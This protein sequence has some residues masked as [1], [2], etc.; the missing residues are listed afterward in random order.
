MASQYKIPGGKEKDVP[1][2]ECTD[3]TLD[4]WANKVAEN[5]A[6][7]AARFPDRDKPF[8][9]AMR[10]EQARRRGEE[11]PDDA[12]SGHAPAEP[13]KAIQRVAPPAEIVTGGFR[14]P[15]RATEALQRAAAHAHLV[16]PATDCGDIREG[17]S[18]VISA[19][20]V[21]AEHETYS[22]AGKLGLSKV[23]LDKIA[24]AAGIS[25]DPRECGRQDDG[26]D[27][28]YCHY[29]AVG[30]VRDFDGTVRLLSGEVEMDAREGSPLIDEIRTK[31]AKRRAEAE[32]ENK[33]YTGDGGDS[34]ILELRKFLLRHAESKAKN[35]AIRELGIRTAYE[36]KE[37]KKPFVVAK[38]ML[39]GH[40]SNPETQRIF[41]EQTAREF[42]SAVPQLYGEP[43]RENASRRG[44]PPVGSVPADDGAIEAEG[45]KMPSSVDASRAPARR[46]GTDDEGSDY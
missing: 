32:R 6:S 7:G 35:R 4:W 11:P 20:L 30:R 37:L 2:D 25:W 40:S 26:K 15:N 21:D 36:P 34:Q 43:T 27:P 14:D 17:C 3:N 1:I 44:A 22:V 13:A 16:S 5:L 12:T 39:T 45:E 9:S 31:A 28:R 42:S 29:K 23:A 41:A 10:A 18:I 38:I 33:K 19:V 24:A 8:L 46:T